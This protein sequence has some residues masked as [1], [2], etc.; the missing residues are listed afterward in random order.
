MVCTLLWEDAMSR[1]TPTNITNE[2]NQDP[3]KDT[4]TIADEP[5]FHYGEESSA[6]RPAR[7][8]MIAISI[9]LFFTAIAVSQFGQA[10]RAR[11]AEFLRGGAK[12]DALGKT[13]TQN[14][15]PGDAA[16]DKV[17]TSRTMEARELTPAVYVSH[18]YGVAWQYP[19]T[20]V[21]RRGQNA[22][23]NLSGKPAVPSAFV[24]PGG[25]TLATVIIPSKLYPGTDLK[26]ASLTVRVNPQISSEECSGFRDPDDKDA[27]LQAGKATVGTIDFDAVDRDAD[28]D[29]AGDAVRT[30]QEKYYHTYENEACYEF[31]M[32]LTT[33]SATGK[34]RKTPIDADDVFD[35]LSEVL[36]SVT[37]VPVRTPNTPAL[38]STE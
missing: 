18:K 19:R 20:Y 4:T 5:I 34:S 9:A 25:L 35:R 27:M 37:I 38:K 17:P 11:Q 24:E 3:S 13:H 8:R 12:I 15:L 23:L 28:D 21:L 16:A 36:T 10:S 1:N 6:P 30:S 14:A 32:K 33:V 7:A 31:A 2:P 22:N 26:S 29:D